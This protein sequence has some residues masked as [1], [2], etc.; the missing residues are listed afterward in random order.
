MK[1]VIPLLFVFCTALAI[2][3]GVLLPGFV[4]SAQDRKLQKTIRTYKTE[5]I[6]FHPVAQVLDSLQLIAGK[7][8]CAIDFSGGGSPDDQGPF[9]TKVRLNADG[10]YKAALEALRFL[11]EQ[12]AVGIEQGSYPIHSEKAQLAISMDQSTCAVVWDCELRDD[13]AGP[14]VDMLIDDQSGKMLSLNVVLNEAPISVKGEN[15]PEKTA[16]NFFMRL[17]TVFSNYYG[18]QCKKVDLDPPIQ[19]NSNLSRL[20]GSPDHYYDVT[21]SAILE[22]KSGATLEIPV[23]SY[24]GTYQFN[25]CDEIIAAQSGW[26]NVGESK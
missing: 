9:S 8:Y 15:S 10:A 5:G 13:R 18:L 19:W 7:N 11:K 17:A 26:M 2:T 16:N 20:K 24:G 6:Q 1:K 21:G 12:G 14:E 4:S 23:K 25:N 3:A 22:D